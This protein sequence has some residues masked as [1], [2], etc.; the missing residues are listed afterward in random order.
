MKCASS[1]EKAILFREKRCGHK[2]PTRQ[3]EKLT[4]F[5]TRYEAVMFYLC[6]WKMLHS[7]IAAYTLEERKTGIVH[8]LYPSTLESDR[9][10]ILK[11]VSKA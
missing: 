1:F 9:Y 8:L 10:N 6:R 11:L 5:C 4:L 7:K 2:I 3:T